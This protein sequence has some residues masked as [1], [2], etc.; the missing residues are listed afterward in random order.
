VLLA[1]LDEQV[2]AVSRLVCSLDATSLPGRD[3]MAVAERFSR[4]VQ[5]AEAGRAVCAGRVQETGAF[6]GE[7]HRDAASWLASLSG[8][9]KGRARGTLE[10]AAGLAEL[11]ALDEALRS[12]RLSGRKAEEVA[13]AAVE[14]RSA[15]G[16]LVEIA[17]A[18]S[19]G[20]LR[21][22]AAKVRAAAS[23]REEDEERQRRLHAKRSLVT[24]NDPDGSFY[25]RF[26]LT[27][28]A[29]AIVLGRLDAIAGRLFE[30]A[31][32]EHRR[33]TRAALLADALVELAQCDGSGAKEPPRKIVMR[34]DL[35]ALVRGE[36]AHGGEASIDGAGHVAVS[37]VQSY[38]D[39][40]E[41]SLIVKRGID[42]CSIYSLKRHIPAVVRAALEERD[43]HCVVPG[44]TSTFHLQIDHRIDF[45]KRGPTAMF[46]LSRLCAFHHQQKTSKGYRLDKVD[47]RWRWR[48]PA[49]PEGEAAPE[50]APE[51]PPVA[52]LPP[53]G[54]LPPGPSTG[55][56]PAPGDTPWPP[57]RT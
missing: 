47:G 24:W 43:R 23:S 32:S 9:S 17:T 53:P 13:R 51:Q 41:L 57:L 5:L 29:G 38:L 8:D 36:L 19:L 16:T 12:G 26:S 27:P 40:A 48:P 34:I 39:K 1:L 20:E 30:R 35:E 49:G 28:E 6:L 25:G 33:E 50:P 21:D 14:D 22:A 2:E 31:R 4:L 7:G 44:C 42:V 56:K 54:K 46:N 11:P 18:S 45:A 37:L 10:L 55:A 15:E 3:A 52:K